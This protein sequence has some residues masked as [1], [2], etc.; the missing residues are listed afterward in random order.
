MR[1]GSRSLMCVRGLV[2]AAGTRRAPAPVASASRCRTQTQQPDS[3]HTPPTHGCVEPGYDR[4]AVMPDTA[5]L[6]AFILVTCTHTPI[7]NNF[8]HPFSHTCPCTR[9]YMHQPCASHALVMLVVL[10]QPCR[11]HPCTAAALPAVPPASLPLQTQLHCH[12]RQSCRCSQ[13]AYI[14]GELWSRGCR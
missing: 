9:T 7:V 12:C 1:I 8:M 6:V 4:D 13:R 2:T 14:E 5:R 3:T 10:P 11:C